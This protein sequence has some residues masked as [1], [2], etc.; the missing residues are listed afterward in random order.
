[1]GDIEPGGLIQSSARKSTLRDRL[2]FTSL[3]DAV[4][5]AAPPQ[6]CGTLP[7]TPEFQ[8][9]MPQIPIERH[10]HDAGQ[11]ASRR[12]GVVL[13]RMAW[14]SPR[15]AMTAQRQRFRRRREIALH[16]MISPVRGY[17]Y[18]LP[19]APAKFSDQSLVFRRRCTRFGKGAAQILP[20]L[21]RFAG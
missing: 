15:A 3:S 14:I 10:L 12:E 7:E 8:P 2:P 11:K 6:Y 21:A 9:L 4:E 18:F 1:M 17:L 20:S 16:T 5:M 13:T 19:D